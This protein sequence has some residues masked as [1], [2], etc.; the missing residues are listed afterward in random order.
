MP[1][2]HLPRLKAQVQELVAKAN[3]VPAFIRQMHELFYF[4]SNRAQ[5]HGQSGTP[6]PVIRWYN[7]PQPVLRALQAELT[8]FADREPELSLLLC[9]AMWAEEIY[10]LRLL[11]AGL[12]GEI[13]PD[14]PD[15]ILQRIQGWA[16][17]GEDEKLLK[18]LINQGFHRLLH[19]KPDTVIKQIEIWL[20]D[21]RLDVQELGLRALVPLVNNPHFEN[22]PAVYTLLG[23]YMRSMPKQVRDHIVWAV[24][25]LA[26]RSPVETAFILRR[27]LEI[28]SSKE[29]AWLAR[30]CLDA[31]PVEARDGLRQALREAMLSEDRAA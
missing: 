14:P 8:P 1:A 21:E 23:P 28:F 7:L 30:Q 10:E 20:T 16:L 27:N 19:E 5:R 13:P 17:P 22:L 12:L 18:A 9:D 24:K 4:Y 15:P 3:D 25:A 29:I 26:R 6:P 2:I 31:F 11:A